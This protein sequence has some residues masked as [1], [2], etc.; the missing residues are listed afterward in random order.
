MDF[1]PKAGVLIADPE[2]LTR[3][4]LAQL[5]EPHPLLRICAEAESVP[6]A[7][8]LCVQHCP[9]LLLIDAAMGDGLG[10]IREL[11][12]W[13]ERTRTV[14]F[15]SRTDA[16]SVQRAFQAGACGYVARRDPVEALLGALV[17]ALKGDRHVGPLVERVLIDELAAGGI[18]LHGHAEGGLSHRE[19]EIFELMGRGLGTRAIAAELRVSVKTVETHRQRMKQKLG[20]TSGAE[21]QQQAAVFAERAAQERRVN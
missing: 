15:T 8:E 7:R 13:C 5:I 18:E 14:V 6:V 11:P 9:D 21:L 2:P 1:P 19:L 17:G 10:F 20:V 4:G 16:W 3:R 12:R